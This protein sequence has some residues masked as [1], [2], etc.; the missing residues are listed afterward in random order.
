PHIAPFP[1]RDATAAIPPDNGCVT[2]ADGPGLL[3]PGEP[4][5]LA[6]H[7]AQH[8]LHLALELGIAEHG[9]LDL[10]DA[11]LAVLAGNTP[12]LAR[13]RG[14]CRLIGGH[15]GLALLRRQVADAED[16]LQMAGRHRNGVAGIGDLGDEAAMLADRLGDLQAQA[17]GAA[18]YIL[19][20]QP[21]IGSDQLVP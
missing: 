9:K 4:L 10:D 13:G 1:W 12:A 16:R 7:M 21:L 2:A 19:L 15:E 18:V 8:V 14:M 5:E 17:R 20:Q 11:A 6:G 3:V